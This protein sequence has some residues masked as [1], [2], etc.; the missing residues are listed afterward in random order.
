MTEQERKEKRKA[1]MKKYLA[2]YSKK[3]YLE[4]KDRILESCREY[5][6]NNKEEIRK[7]QNEYAKIYRKKNK[8]KLNAYSKNRRQNDPIYKIRN[9]LRT[10]IYYFLKSKKFVKS[11]STEEI[12]GCDYECFKKHIESLFKENMNWDNH[13]EWHIDH[14]I[15]LSSANSD[16]DIIKLCNYKN[17]Q[18]LWANENLKKNKY[19]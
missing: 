14:I 15:P 7:Q 2:S 13:G 3:Y 17:L 11:K 6:N 5:Y 9:I 4:N 16:N 10:R 1:Y 12:I 8:D 19:Y 18:P